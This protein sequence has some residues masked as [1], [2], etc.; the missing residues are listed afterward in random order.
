MPLQNVACIYEYS[1]I[2]DLK[3][4]LPNSD[5]LFCMEAFSF[6]ETLLDVT[7]N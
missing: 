1:V 4:T 6:I 7:L 3:D 2:M 5:L